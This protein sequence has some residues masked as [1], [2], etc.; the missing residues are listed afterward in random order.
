MSDLL[1]SL[2]SYNVLQNAATAVATPE[3]PA[4][5]VS[6]VVATSEDW[7]VSSVEQIVT[8]EEDHNVQS[9]NTMLILFALNAD[10]QLCFSDINS[11]TPLSILPNI[12]FDVDSGYNICPASVASDLQIYDYVNWEIP[13][14]CSET[15]VEIPLLPVSNF[16]DSRIMTAC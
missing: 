12:S 10:S 13:G 9:D 7:C 4:P 6:S 14:S 8:V 16:L 5:V 15:S 11:A 2:V 1:L 3:D